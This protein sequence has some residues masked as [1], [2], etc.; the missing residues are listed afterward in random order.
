MKKIIKSPCISVLFYSVMGLGFFYFALVYRKEIALNVTKTIDYCLGN[1]IPS[2]FPMIFISAFLSVSAAKKLFEFSF[3]FVCRY[4][5]KLPK[6]CATVIVFGL[7]CGYPVGSKLASK[8]LE[9]GEIN[10][11]QANRL[12]CFCISPG[13]PFAIIFVGG[14][15]LNSVFTGLL[16]FISITVSSLFFGVILG[17]KKPVPEVKTNSY[18]TL[19][20]NDCMTLSAKTAMSSTVTLCLYVLIFSMFL[21]VLRFSGLYE[22]IVDLVFVNGLF[23]KKECSVLLAFFFEVVDGVNAANTLKVN[24][25]IIV[26]GLSFGGLCVHFQLFSFFKKKTIVIWKFYFNRVLISFTSVQIL[27]FLKA[28]FPIDAYVFSTTQTIIPEISKSTAT[29]S[30]CLILLCCT[31]IFLNKR[32]EK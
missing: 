6:C 31:Y 1:L 22:K 2:L 25:D 12:C 18:Q 23:L 10:K 28:M 8:L 30:L 17:I 7:C 21:T 11:E 29:G 32:L 26:L 27:R 14:V 15:V 20:F 9:S 19:N 3:S 13:I 5:L 4:L 16:I 24:S